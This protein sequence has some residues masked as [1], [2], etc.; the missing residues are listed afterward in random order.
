[1]QPHTLIHST[2]NYQLDLGAKENRGRVASRGWEKKITEIPTGWWGD[3]K[4]FQFSLAAPFPPC[5]L[6]RPTA[7]EGQRSFGRTKAEAQRN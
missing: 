3:A 4:I 1:M 6:T 5:V 2:L 7:P